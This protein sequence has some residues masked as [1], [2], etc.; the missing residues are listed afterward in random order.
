MTA[1][2]FVVCC[3]FVSHVPIQVNCKQGFRSLSTT[4]VPT[5][6]WYTQCKPLCLHE[7]I[8]HTQLFQWSRTAVPIRRNV[9]VHSNRTARHLQLFQHLF[10][11][12]EHRSPHSHNHVRSKQG[13]MFTALTM[14]TQQVECVSND[15]TLHTSTPQTKTHCTP[16]HVTGALVTICR[17]ALRIRS[18]PFQLR[19]LKQSQTNS[20]CSRGSAN[21]FLTTMHARKRRKCS[22][23]PTMH[24]PSSSS[25]SLLFF[26]FDHASLTPNGADQS[27][28][29]RVLAPRTRDYPKL[30]NQLLWRSLLDRATSRI[31]RCRGADALRFSSR[32]RPA[33]GPSLGSVQHR[34]AVTCRL[35]LGVAGHTSRLASG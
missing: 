23:L 26:S 17:T 32:V 25:T 13:K 27:S 34:A 19:S 31:C 4:T 18:P 3:S 10:L 6:Q 1:I 5:T 15:E 9:N 24:F 28:T 29:T 20:K 11:V 21:T 30:R 14:N 22:S 12:R 8:R 35:L 33:V 2:S 16:A 7:R